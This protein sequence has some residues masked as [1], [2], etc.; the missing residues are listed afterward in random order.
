MAFKVPLSIMYNLYCTRV[1]RF[2]VKRVIEK[3][4]ST[5]KRRPVEGRLGIADVIK[6]SLILVPGPHIRNSE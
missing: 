5:P 6:L 1:A 3:S 4:L 2:A